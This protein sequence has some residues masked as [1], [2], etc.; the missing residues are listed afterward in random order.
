MAHPSQNHHF[1]F[2]PVSTL[3][4][5]Q[6]DLTKDKVIFFSLYQIFWDMNHCKKPRLAELLQA[7]P[8]TLLAGCW[9]SWA[10]QPRLILPEPEGKI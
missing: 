7:G 1:G 3:C 4:E 8:T 2:R 5:L 9:E 6:R 10:R